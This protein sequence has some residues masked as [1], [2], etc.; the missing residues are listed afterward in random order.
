MPYT[1]TSGYTGRD[2]FT[3]KV[4]D[5]GTDSS[6]ATATMTVTGGTPTTITLNPIADT[7]VNSGSPTATYGATTPICTREDS[8]AANPTYRVYFKFTVPVLSGS[9]KSVKLRLFVTTCDAQ[10]TDRLRGDRQ[11]VDRVGLS[12]TGPPIGGPASASGHGVPPP[13]TSR[14]RYPIR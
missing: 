7:Q 4:N 9:V 13:P 5:G 10:H 2:S 11:D 14:S 3:Y 8:N 12:W 1:P 6:T